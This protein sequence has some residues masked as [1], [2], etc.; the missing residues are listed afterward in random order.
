MIH[1]I[2]LTQNLTD[3]FNSQE[4][5]RVI[6]V[7]VENIDF[8]YN[9]HIVFANRAIDVYDSYDEIKDKINKAQEGEE[10]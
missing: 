9:N 4:N 5:K 10:V 6:S 7:A 1:F 3:F 2:E 8:Y